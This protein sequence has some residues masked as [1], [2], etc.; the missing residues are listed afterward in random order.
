MCF[1]TSVHIS[2]YSDG[3]L[4]MLTVCTTVSVSS[5]LVGVKMRHVSGLEW[6]C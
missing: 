4:T 6:A 5:Q 2:C 3:I 1:N